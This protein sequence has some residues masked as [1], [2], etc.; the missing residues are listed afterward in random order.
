MFKKEK[1]LKDLLQNALIT[2]LTTDNSDDLNDS[3]ELLKTQLSTSTPL[4]ELNFCDK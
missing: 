4:V 2:A 1:V 3:I